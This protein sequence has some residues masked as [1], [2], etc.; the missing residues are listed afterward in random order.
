MQIGQ[1]ADKV[2]KIASHL[3]QCD[4]F[5]VYICNVSLQTYILSRCKLILVRSSSEEKVL[6]CLEVE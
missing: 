6:G 5:L 2:Q 4:Y 3:S 1:Q